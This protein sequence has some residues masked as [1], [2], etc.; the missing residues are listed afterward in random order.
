MLK[1]ERLISRGH[2]FIRAAENQ[3]L[4]DWV[5]CQF[6]RGTQRIWNAQQ[7]NNGTNFTVKTFFEGFISP[8]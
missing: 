5:S 3:E 7:Q 2:I 1:G 4:A 8:D 6:G